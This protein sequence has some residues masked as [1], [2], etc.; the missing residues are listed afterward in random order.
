[1]RRQS[2][3]AGAASVEHV[4]LAFLLAVVIARRSPRLPPRRPSAR[5]GELG[6]AI[7]ERIACAPR[8]PV[9]CHRNPLALAYGFPLGKL[10][11]LLA[12]APAAALG[13]GGAPLLPVDFRRC[14]IGRAAR[15]RGRSPG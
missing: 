14:R 7:A 15:C 12:P 13:P 9:P 8:H 2:G 4:A 6:A 11:R 5:R 10:V 1:M 3:E